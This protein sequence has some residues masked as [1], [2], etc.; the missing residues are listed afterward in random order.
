MQ[1]VVDVEPFIEL[2]ELPEESSL[3]FVA[4]SAESDEDSVTDAA[5][6]EQPAAALQPP[7]AA[8]YYCAPV[9]MPILPP[10]P[11]ATLHAMWYQYQLQ[12]ALQIMQSDPTYMQRLALS[13]AVPAIIPV[14]QATRSKRPPR[15]AP[16]LPPLR[17]IQPFADIAQSKRELKAWTSAVPIIYRGHQY[18]NIAD[19][20]VPIDQHEWDMCVQRRSARARFFNLGNLLHD[21][22]NSCYR[23]YVRRYR[24]PES[25]AKPFAS[26]HVYRTETEHNLLRAC[27]P[28]VLA[29]IG[30]RTPLVD[31]AGQPTPLWMCSI[32]HESLRTTE[33]ASAI[34]MQ[35][36][37]L[38]A[39]V[40]DCL[41]AL[42]YME[43]HL[44]SRVRPFH[45]LVYLPYGQMA[46]RGLS[47]SYPSN[48]SEIREALPAPI[49]EST[50]VFIRTMTKD[51]TAGDAS[52]V[53]A[54]AVNAE[55]MIRSKQKPK[56][57]RVHPFIVHS[58]LDWLQVNN[59]LYA[60]VPRNRDYN[61]EELDP[62]SEE[63][64]GLDLDDARA[65]HSVDAAE[66][67]PDADAELAST[68]GAD[69]IVP[70]HRPHRDDESDS[71]SV[72]LTD[73]GDHDGSD[74]AYTGSLASELE[75]L[76]FRGLSPPDG[77]D[78]NGVLNPVMTNQQLPVQDRILRPVGLHQKQTPMYELQRVKHTKPI[79]I[80]YEKSSEALAYPH[81]F[82]NGINHYGTRRYAHITPL[83]YF[84]S[85]LASLYRD[86]CMVDLSYLYF[87]VNAIDWHEL[88]S[89]VH[90]LFKK[91]TGLQG[92]PA[93]SGRHAREIPL[94]QRGLHSSDGAAGITKGELLDMAISN[95][96]DDQRWFEDTCSTFMKGMRGTMAYWNN[97]KRNLFSML[98]TLGPFTW[99]VTFSANEMGWPECIMSVTGQSREVVAAMTDAQK[100]EVI[101]N[102]PD[103]VAKYFD[104]RW[105]F[106]FTTVLKGKG[107]PIGEIV[108]YFWRVE[109]QRRGSP[110]IHMV[111]WVKDAPDMA[112]EAGRKAAPSFIERYISTCVPDQP[113]QLQD[114]VKKLQTHHHTHTCYKGGSG[115]HGKCRFHM[116]RPPSA[117]TRLTNDTDRGLP[118]RTVYVTKRVENRDESINAYNP[119][120]LL[121]WQSN[122]DIQFAG[123]LHGLVAYICAYMTKDE[124]QSL[125]Q[126]I[127]EALA[128]L[129]PNSSRF[130]KIFRIG[131]VILSKREL[132]AQEAV[133]KI[134]G[135]PLRSA[136]RS[137]QEL[138]TRPAERR[139]R[140]LRRGFH[141]LPDDSTDIFQG[142]VVTRYAERPTNDYPDGWDE[143]HSAKFNVPRPC[144]RIDWENMT[145]AQFAAFWQAEPSTKKRDR[146]SIHPWN[147][148]FVLQDGRTY[149]K[150]CRRKCLQLPYFNP[151]NRDEDY[152]YSMLML[153]IPWRNESEIMKG[154]QSPM[155]AFVERASEFRMSSREEDDAQDSTFAQFAEEV[156]HAVNQIHVLHRD[157]MADA[158]DMD[159]ANRMSLTDRV[160]ATL[161]REGTSRLEDDNC[162]VNEMDDQRGYLDA[163]DGVDPA[164][165][166]TNLADTPDH[167]GYAVTGA[168]HADLTIIR[169]EP[170]MA[171]SQYRQTIAN[172]R[173]YPKQYDVFCR[174]QRHVRRTYLTSASAPSS[175]PHVPLRLFITGGA[176]VGKSYVIKCVRELIMMAS[177]NRGCMSCAP[178]G[179]AA[180]NINGRTLHTALSIPVDQKEM[181]T[182]AGIC[183]PLQSDRLANM[184]A[185][186]RDVKYLIIDEVSMVSDSMMAK[187]NLRLNQILLTPDEAATDQFT[188]GNI[189]VISIGDF[190]QLKPVKAQYCFNPTSDSGRTLWSQ[191]ELYELTENVRQSGD[192]VWSELLNRIREGKATQADMDLLRTRVSR[193]S[194]RKRLEAIDASHGVTLTRA[195]NKQRERDLLNFVDDSLDPFTNA[196]RIYSLKDQCAAYNRQRTR[197]MRH[198]DA[199]AVY[200]LDAEHCILN[201]N[202]G[203]GQVGINARTVSS[204]L[205]PTG[206]DDCGGLSKTLRLGIGS[207]VMLR[208]NISVLEGLVNGACGVVESIEWTNGA[209]MQ[210]KPGA[211]P[212]RVWV[213][214]DNRRVGHMEADRNAGNDAAAHVAIAIE[215]ATGRFE[216]VGN[217]GI[218]LTRTQIPLLLCWAATVHKVQ[219]IT[220]DYAVVDLTAPWCCALAYV[221]LSRV[222]T[223]QG[224]VIDGLGALGKISWADWR[225][226]KEYKRLRR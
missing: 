125:Q 151:Q 97:T 98:N 31:G 12:C 40:P 108:D 7:T 214:F 158:V 162:M 202:P 4:E 110:H 33:R 77:I 2:V 56:Q 173:K 223:L 170:P 72:D 129:P 83:E 149:V 197:S 203:S 105:R 217:I 112:T 213:K 145:L 192:P 186:W 188:F 201:A 102:N 79:R 69:R 182:G 206:D 30:T 94:T 130:K 104:M 124:P 128:D 50:F 85:R 78:H 14:Q 204:D 180:F 135:I 168:S 15:V 221:A 174:I 208:K 23:H 154:F 171:I 115:R 140:I 68:V 148:P 82:V 6:V 87:A 120:L 161:R 58:A 123:S 9:M 5:A 193:S 95:A 175:D 29:D 184:Q 88:E 54:E 70:Q 43:R 195:Q 61:M 181:R 212:A 53:H 41:N 178:T 20:T 93:M 136:S 11:P 81:I 28:D 89:Q 92:A 122:M 126:C 103:L 73:V 55:D 36:Q 172:L 163:D 225:V 176:G 157:A 21:T 3:V 132:C 177:N 34:S 52:T 134:L 42:N 215:P 144:G 76:T 150:R 27:I 47:I 209:S 8:Q 185:L 1:M 189:S 165:A 64:T 133:Y 91:I 66:L 75:A 38:L 51:S 60:G 111:I 22:C 86:R 205:I 167:R 155:E 139:V 138:N 17:D 179:V 169:A 121:A 100:R 187:V 152:Y 159:L 200:K 13:V 216:A 90:I 49:D 143:S 44:I 116:P 114:L 19:V 84:K 39:P 127:R 71:Q 198:D 106:F 210:S 224:L 113:G 131:T 218:Y 96:K 63:I 153:H 46:A 48:V 166:I 137:F 101:A 74:S 62:Y 211:L 226:T 191:F 190:Y 222:T 57:Y 18:L 26:G 67:Y 156:S 10:L 147:G 35:N 45:H 117:S 183:A 160:A 25:R 109:F 164:N 65:D 219:G 194:E 119:E 141:Y 32:C 220:L 199:T 196:L 99:F 118:K 80:N 24:V 16:A 207:R 146:V 59:P 37:L 142:N 107:Q